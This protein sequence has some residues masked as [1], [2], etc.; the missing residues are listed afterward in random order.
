MSRHD[1]AVDALR[2]VGG[3]PEVA[4]RLERERDD[5]RAHAYR[6][7]RDSPEITDWRWTA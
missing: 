3:N 6:E 1:L 2:R 5:L 4:E 7:G